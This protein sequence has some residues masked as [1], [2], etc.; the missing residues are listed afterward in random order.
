[1][2]P[3]HLGADI[4]LAWPTVQIAVMGA[5]GTASILHRRRLAETREPETERARLIAGYEENRALADPPAHRQ[6]GESVGD[7]T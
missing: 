3:K 7:P 2:T 5:Q 6:L 1:M 4:N